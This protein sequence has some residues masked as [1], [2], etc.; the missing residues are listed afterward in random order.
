[1]FETPDGTSYTEVHHIVPLAEGG[2]DTIENVACLCPAHHREIHL[3]RR[4]AELTVQLKTMR[5]EES[6]D[7]E[8]S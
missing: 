8:L 6:T 5:A 4:A 7:L 3:G 2:E 1:M